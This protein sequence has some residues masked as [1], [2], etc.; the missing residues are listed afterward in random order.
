MQ[1]KVL[2]FAISISILLFMSQLRAQNNIEDRVEQVFKVADSLYKQGDALKALDTMLFILPEFNQFQNDSLESKVLGLFSHLQKNMGNDTVGIGRFM[3]NLKVHQLRKYLNAVDAMGH[4]FERREHYIKALS[5]YKKMILFSNRM[6]DTLKLGEA[7]FNTGRMFKALLNFPK[8]Q[9]YFDQSMEFYEV[10]D[11]KTGKVKLYNQVGDIYAQKDQPDSAAAYFQKAIQIAKNS[12]SIHNRIIAYHRLANIMSERDNYNEASSYYQHAIEIASSRGRELLPGILLDYGNL[13]EKSGKTDKAIEFYRQCSKSAVAQNNT[14]VQ[15]S[16]AKKLAQLYASRKSNRLAIRYYQR[17]IELSDSMQKINSLQEMARFEARYNLMQKEQEI[18]LLDRERKLKEAKL[19]NQELRSRL[20][21]GGL[22]L[23]AL[24][25]GVLLYH[26]ITHIRKNR[27]LSA[28]NVQINDQNEELSQI[29]EQLS[30]SENRLMQALS[31]KNKL[32]AIIGHDLK[33]P[34]MDIKNLIFILKNN[35]G[36]FS[37]EDLKKHSGQIENRLT[38]ILELLNNLLN[39]GMAERN[40]LKY[41]PREIDVVQLI[42]DTIRLFDGALNSKQIKINLQLE[43]SIQWKTDFNM[44]EFI[45]RNV[46]SNAIKFSDI[47]DKIDLIARIEKDQLKIVIEDEGIGMTE[48][49]LEQIFV[50]TSEKIRRGTQKE[51]GTGLGMSV[52]QDFINQM[53]G[54]ILVESTEGKGTKVEISIRR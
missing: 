39:W 4:Y 29:N 35:P 40:T 52:S 38:G 16:A 26:I 53:G 54:K 18:G 24:L 50:R 11:T 30:A 9:Q 28:Q 14:A 47:G 32:F 6:N 21:F 17:S 37:A 41:T 45:L 13:F 1:L 44:L 20:Y 31:T 10:V 19:K 27:L 49:Q 42:Q 36:Q 43:E 25:V 12:N 48:Q 33:S 34:L 46:L 5:Y 8:A 15:I 23:L 3:E 7:Y 22:I 2:L 51:K